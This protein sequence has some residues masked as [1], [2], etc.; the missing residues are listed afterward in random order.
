MSSRAIWTVA[1]TITLVI[2]AHAAP[3]KHHDKATPAQFKGN[4]TDPAFRTGY[5]DGYRQGSNDSHALGNYADESGP[6]YA[7]ALDGYTSQYG[8]EESYKK[9]FRLG[10]INGYKDGFD[11]NFGMYNSLGC[12]GGSP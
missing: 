6:Y 9:L 12:G 11:S 4:R 1:V 8:D 5:D 3:R 7:A 2:S 10:Y